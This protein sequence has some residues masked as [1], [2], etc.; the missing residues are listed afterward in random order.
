VAL[1]ILALRGQRRISTDL[2]ILGVLGAAYSIFAF[3]GMGQE[4]FLW[5][6]ALAAVGAPVFLVMRLSRAKARVAPD[7]AT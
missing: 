2:L 3:I 5:A 4:P 7:S 1:T 6:L